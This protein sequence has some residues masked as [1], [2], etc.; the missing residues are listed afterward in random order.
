MASPHEYK[1]FADDVKRVHWSEVTTGTIVDVYP[2][3]TADVNISG[4]G[5]VAAVPIFYHCEQAATVEDGHEAFA[6]DDEVLVLAEKSST[7]DGP[8]Y[9]II[10]FTNSPLRSCSKYVLV[11]IVG[12]SSSGYQP[13]DDCE[14]ILWDVKNNQPGILKDINSGDV[15]SGQVVWS[16]IKDT[17]LFKK[18]DSHPLFDFRWFGEHPDNYCD[19]QIE[20]NSQWHWCPDHIFGWTEV[21]I[22]TWGDCSWP[23][24]SH[25]EDLTY[26]ESYYKEEY[27]NEVHGGDFSTVENRTIDLS[28]NSDETLYYGSDADRFAKSYRMVYLAPHSKEGELE[29]VRGAWHFERGEDDAGSYESPNPD[30]CPPWHI[31]IPHREGIQYYHATT[32]LVTP[33]GSVVI[34]EMNYSKVYEQTNYGYEDPGP[35]LF[36]EDNHRMSFSTLSNAEIDNIPL[37]SPMHL[38]GWYRGVL[39]QIYVEFHVISHHHNDDQG[40]Q[41]HTYQTYWTA[42]AGCGLYEESFVQNTPE[43]QW[44]NGAFSAAIEALLGNYWGSL[45]LLDAE[46]GPEGHNFYVYLVKE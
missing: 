10:G 38:F 46:G 1:D 29:F 25:G 12:P 13:H 37:S 27:R 42:H 11:F 39:Y 22:L 41:S 28:D 15:F 40:N 5:L 20:D 6:A 9:T 18:V 30:Y 21:D 16:D 24:V 2:D 34:N 3:N 35:L 45:G 19:T 36:E 8:D 44:K 31:W 4:A 33:L 7:E 26:T 43:A 14:C 23:S 17:V 32:N